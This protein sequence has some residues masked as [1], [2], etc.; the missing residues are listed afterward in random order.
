MI[1]FPS[2]SITHE[3][4][5][6]LV[7]PRVELITDCM[8]KISG[9]YE[10]LCTVNKGNTQV[11]S[12]RFFREL[13]TQKSYKIYRH[14][15][16]VLTTKTMSPVSLNTDLEFLNSHFIEK[17]LSEFG[18]TKIILELVETSHLDTV[19]RIK[20]RIN[21]IKVNPRVAIWLDDF[22]TERANFDLMNLVHF[23]A[24]KMSKEL[25]WDLFEN[26][27]TLLK[28]LVKMIK[29]KASIIVIEGVDSFDKYIFCKE[30]QCLMQGY[31]FNE[32][33]SSAVC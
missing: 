7:Y 14:V 22:G 19:V 17:L 5:H 24:V 27:K 8:S 20:D 32:V 3:A 28:Y 1:V 21:E 12:T 30:Q 16:N 26:D 2:I 6:F 13:S 23:D 9:I 15:L 25:F 11:C 33:E 31:F 10:V 4:N 29:R 18:G